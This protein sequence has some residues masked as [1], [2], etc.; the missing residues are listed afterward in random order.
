MV[1]DHNF[2]FNPDDWAFCRGP[3]NWF[4]F[5]CP[6]GLKV[7]QN[8]TIF[9]IAPESG[10]SWSQIANAQN[11]TSSSSPAAMIDTIHR[12]SQ[13]HGSG[14]DQSS[15]LI[16]AAWVDEP[17]D[18]GN[19]YDVS[20]LFPQV[21]VAR[22]ARPLAV[23]GAR[24]ALSGISSRQSTGNWFRRI[25][26]R[27][28]A[29]Q[30]RFWSLQRGS[31]LIAVSIQSPRRGGLNEPTIAICEA[32]LNSME[33]ADSPSWPPE[34]FQRQVV[35]LGKKTF[36]LLSVE[37][38]AGFAVAV[39][40]SEISLSNFY[41]SYLQN[42]E[43]FSRIVLPGLTTVVRLRE[44]GP[45]QILPTLDNVR[46][47]ILPMLSCDEELRSEELVKTPWVGGLNVGYVV[48]EDDA[49]RFVHR[50]M[51]RHWDLDFGQLHDLAMENLR[52]YAQQHPLEVTMV[53]DEDDPQMLM[54]LK[55]DAY[56]SSRI[57]DPGFHGKLRELF[58]P[59]LV[60][61]V[62][63]RDFFVAVSL[64]H[65]TLLQQVQD[66]V[67]RDHATMH[68][69]LTERLLVISADGVSEFIQG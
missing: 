36:P 11:L 18:T 69:P 43:H 45:D 64:R 57:L 19:A 55:P 68:H 54:P 63:N 34:V 52:S 30:W 20:V 2:Q 32:M 3:A 17:A 56:N 37:A 67:S 42:P 40:E 65:P 31:V 29:Y 14:D 21:S 51:L 48:D 22:R 46:D 49:Y 7:C 59:E 5:R 66:R 24:S 6:P 15:L 16:C 23:D 62:P 10:K 1:F 12:Q 60:V 41:R 53:G 28:Q 33:L 47:R 9:E 39:E 35:E 44:L 38:A 26:A 58:G 61:G 25:F 27:R 50:R 8:E 4:Q 13:P